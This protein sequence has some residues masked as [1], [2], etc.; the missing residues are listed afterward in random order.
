MTKEQAFKAWIKAAE[1]HTWGYDDLWN[2][3]CDWQKEQDKDI[4]MKYKRMEFNAKLQKEIE[5]LQKE[6]DYW[7]NKAIEY[8]KNQTFY[9]KF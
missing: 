5:D 9:K 7:F 3:A 8:E 1:N 4:P 2:A 6:R